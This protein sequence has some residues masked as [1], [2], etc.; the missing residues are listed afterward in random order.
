[1]LLDL[2]VYAFQNVFLVHHDKIIWILQF[3]FGK[4]VRA[5][6]ISEIK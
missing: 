4:Y 5:D 1:M 6:A 2:K 3:K